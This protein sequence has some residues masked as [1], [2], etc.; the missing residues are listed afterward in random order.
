MKKVKIKKE[1][2]VFEIFVELLN[3]V[4]IQYLLACF[5]ISFKTSIISIFLYGTKVFVM[6][7]Y[8]STIENML[9]HRLGKFLLFFISV[10]IYITLLALFG[11]FPI[12]LTLKE[13]FK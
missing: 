4:I 7:K 13:V 2:L 5:L 11:Y 8:W 6:S 12:S 3:F 1:S 10:I 9:D